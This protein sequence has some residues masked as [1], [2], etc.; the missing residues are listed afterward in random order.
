M[1]ILFVHME[2]LANLFLLCIYQ[3]KMC[4]K[5]YCVYV[6]SCGP[7]SNSGVPFPRFSSSMAIFRQFSENVPQTHRV[8]KC[9]IL[10]SDVTSLMSTMMSH[11]MSWHCTYIGHVTFYYKRSADVSVGGSGLW[12]IRSSG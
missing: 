4:T 6:V 5:I 12:F 3:R 8:Q 9:I 1:Q 11:V 2:L 7:P 10:F